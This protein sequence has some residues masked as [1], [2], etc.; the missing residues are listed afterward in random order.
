MCLYTFTALMV[1]VERTEV[2]VYRY[3]HCLESQVGGRRS[4]NVSGG[5]AQNHRHYCMMSPNRRY[6][7]RIL[8]LAGEEGVGALG[9]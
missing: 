7:Y 4:I 1:E 5:P 2:E 9:N 6:C 3:Q 8:Y